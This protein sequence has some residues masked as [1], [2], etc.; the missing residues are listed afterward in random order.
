ME[1]ADPVYCAGHWVPEMV[2]LAGGRD[3]L[4]HRGSDSVRITWA[5][6]VEWAPEI[7][8]FA[9]CGFN[10]ETAIEQLPYLEGLPGWAELPA[11]RN[12]RAYV[13]DANSYF[14]R[15]G[16]RVV[17]GTELL[18]H[19]I[20]PEL[21]DWNG[22][23]DAVQAASASNKIS[24][25]TRKKCPEC[26]QTFECQTDGCWCAD[27]PHLR[28]GTLPASDCLCPVCLGNAVRLNATLP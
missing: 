13:V 12:R 16:P 20:H 5:D 26:G 7:I 3:E 25:T 18:A 1:W 10:L 11:V 14:A 23:K 8:V 2:D 21:F 28:R 17:E 15:P 22:P 27:L 9:P 4:A 6:V 24:T 19:L